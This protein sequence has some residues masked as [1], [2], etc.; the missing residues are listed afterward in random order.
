MQLPNTHFLPRQPVETIGTILSQADVL[1]VH[2]KDD[3]L[4]RITIPSKTQAYLAAGRPIIMAVPGDA[5]D[6]ITQAGAGLV[7]PP[8]DPTA[9]A[10]AVKQ[11]STMYPRQREAMGACGKACYEQQLSLRVGVE[12]FESV[13]RAAISDRRMGQVA[14]HV[15]Q[16][17]N[18]SPSPLTRQTCTPPQRRAA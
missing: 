7:C 14:N 17:V 5:A 15:A 13:F 1:L 18:L 16:I 10:S 2:L 8:E 6:L 11:L 4:F 12:K 3:P 9:L